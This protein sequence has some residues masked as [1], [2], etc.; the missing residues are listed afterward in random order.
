M[1]HVPTQ[2]TPTLYSRIGDSVAYAALAGLAGLIGWGIARAI[3][4]RRGKAGLQLLGN[5]G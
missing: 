5:Q 2:R 4:A 1:A 3:Q